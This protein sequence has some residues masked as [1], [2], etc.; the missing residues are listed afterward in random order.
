MHT[1]VVSALLWRSRTPAISALLST[2]FAVGWQSWIPFSASAQ[3][4]P[5]THSQTS[6]TQE[7]AIQYDWLL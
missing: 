7:F 2:C 6:K 4:A 5:A 3:L 1:C